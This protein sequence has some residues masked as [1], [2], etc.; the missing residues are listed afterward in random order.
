MANK[1]HLLL[2]LKPEIQQHPKHI[3]LHEIQHL[4]LAGYMYHMMHH[5]LKFGE[6]STNNNQDYG[7]QMTDTLKP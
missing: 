1:E 2:K 7:H 4:R 3:Y 5:L 6:D